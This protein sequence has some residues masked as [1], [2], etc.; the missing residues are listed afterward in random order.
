M[1]AVVQRV[2]SAS[3]T[4][5]GGERREIAKGFLIYLGVGKGDTSAQAQRLSEKILNLRI[6]PNTDSKFDKSVLDLKGE[7]LVI[8]QFTLFGDPWA[9]RRPD[10]TSAAPPAE[11]KQLYKEFVGMVRKS[12]LTVKTG[13]FAA[14]MLVE[15]VNDGP[16]TIWVDLPPGR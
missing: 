11:A 2:N 8:S 6:F 16:V 1:R 9:G 12:G 15:S 13:E 10:F 3:V 14:H 5:P 7:L 4:L